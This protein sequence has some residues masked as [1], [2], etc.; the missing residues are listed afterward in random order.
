MASRRVFSV[1]GDSVGFT[2]RIGGVSSL[3]GTGGKGETIR[4]GGSVSAFDATKLGICCMIKHR[5]ACSRRDKALW[6]NE[7]DM[8]CFVD[9]LRLRPSADVVEDLPEKRRTKQCCRATQGRLTDV[10]AA[11]TE[12]SFSIE[13]VVV[14]KGANVLDVRYAMLKL[15]VQKRVRHK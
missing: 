3:D 11:S 2:Y 12:T 14:I 1:S 10:T 5:F 6:R 8:G 13:I 9:V 7:Q 15:P 4:G